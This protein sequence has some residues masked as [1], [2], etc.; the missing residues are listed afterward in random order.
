MPP[1]N[2]WQKQ[3]CLNPRVW[4]DM[5][6]L[7]PAVTR[8]GG[9]FVVVVRTTTWPNFLQNIGTNLPLNPDN[10]HLE[11]SPNND[12]NEKSTVVYRPS[13]IS[14]KKLDQVVNTTG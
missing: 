3:L 14:V 10:D 5:T 1:S 6:P 12:R 4:I 9:S 8:R 2:I 11:I 7:V 13:T